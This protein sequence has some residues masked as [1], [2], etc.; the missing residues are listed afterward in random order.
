MIVDANLLVYAVN[1]RAVRHPESARWIAEQL[2][3]P[4]RVGFPWQTITA[5][6]RIV[7]HP[8]LFAQPL[9]PATAWGQVTDWLSAPVAWV[10]EPGPRYA[11]LLETLITRYD[12]RGNLVPD[13]VL[14]ALAIEHGVTLASADTDFARFTEL[15]WTNPLG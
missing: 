11:Q 6:L 9:G 1:Q 3:G 5:F 15:R 8:R 13:A 7:T 12:V 14:A 2:G 4:Q 10:P